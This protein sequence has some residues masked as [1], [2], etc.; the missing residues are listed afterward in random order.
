[1]LVRAM[2]F[3]LSHRLRYWL[4]GLGQFARSWTLIKR[5][6]MAAFLWKKY[7]SIFTASYLS[8]HMRA[9]AKTQSA[10]IRP[11]RQTGF[12]H[13]LRKQYLDA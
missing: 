6:S 3:P 12:K 13:Y 8:P 10:T 11:F 5:G 9:C 1:V 2:R 7:L 4:P